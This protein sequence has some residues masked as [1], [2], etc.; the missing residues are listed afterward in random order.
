MLNTIFYISD[1]YKNFGNNIIE[2]SDFGIKLSYLIKS[3]DQKKIVETYQFFSTNLIPQFSLTIIIDAPFDDNFLYYLVSFFFLPNYLKTNNQ[4]VIN[5]IYKKEDLLKN[6]QDDL[7]K[8]SAKQGIINLQ[9]NVLTYDTLNAPPNALHKSFHVFSS[10]NNFMLLYINTLQS[11]TFYNNTFYVNHLAID[12]EKLHS[13]ITIENDSFKINN[14]PLYDVAL[15]LQIQTLENS[16]FQIKQTSLLNELD[17]YKTHIAVLKSVHEATELQ[18]Y[19]D[20]EY[21]VLPIWYK[22]FGH[23]LK[24]LMGKRNFKSLFNNK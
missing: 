5:F 2:Q 18:L 13:I 16:N 14:R 11:L 1:N 22:R 4:I 8:I 10:I 17:N 3:S 19:Y 7:I 21:E 24:L 15:A 6:E 23:I 20:K 12:V 9:I